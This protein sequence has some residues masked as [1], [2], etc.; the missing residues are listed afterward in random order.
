MPSVSSFF[1]QATNFGSSVS[2]GVDP[3][4][5][6]YNVRIV[7]GHLVGNR[8][9]GPS[10]PLALGYSPLDGTDI[11]FGRGFSPGLTTYDT[12]N[13]LLVL[14]TGERYKVVET[15]TSVLPQQKKL[16]TVRI[17]KD[18]DGDFYRI[19]H[20]SGEVEILTGPQNAFGLK[21]PTEL[22][23]PAGHRLS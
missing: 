20:K 17:G 9:L 2:G 18:E 11:G 13:A 7:L 16:D 22:L 1:T 23:T 15:D 19:V 8:N 10:F 3:R 21:V 6:L 12:D 4:T 5:G 14:S